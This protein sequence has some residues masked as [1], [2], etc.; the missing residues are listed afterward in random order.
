M[1]PTL[2]VNPTVLRAVSVDE[3]SVTAGIS[4]TGATAV[5]GEAAAGVAGSRTEGGCRL[6]NQCWMWQIDL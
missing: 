3:K 2:Q 5:L 6:A 1:V 4:H